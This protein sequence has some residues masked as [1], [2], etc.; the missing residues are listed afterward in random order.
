VK[1]PFRAVCFGL[2]LT[3]LAFSTR[4]NPPFAKYI[5]PAG[6]QRG[7]TVQAKVGGCF[8]HGE[9]GFEM[10]GAGVQAPAR[11]RE[12]NTVWFEGPLI[13]QP[14]SQRPEDYPKDHAAR[15]RLRP[16]PT[17]GRAP[18]GAWTS[19]GATPAMQF[20]VGDLPEVS[21]RKWK[22]HLSRFR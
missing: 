13:P 21:K 8:F 14:A 5:F 1:F 17:L 19:Q 11:I 6:G 16:T 10:L 15:S 12:I 22:V 4:A 2:L 7:T 9:A 20:V 18:G 3:S